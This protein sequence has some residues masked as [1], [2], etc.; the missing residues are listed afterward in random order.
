ME[1]Q[2]RVNDKA[3]EQLTMEKVKMQMREEQLQSST[4]LAHV[5][6]E[7]ERTHKEIQ[8]MRALNY[9]LQIE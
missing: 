2:L 6:D 1:Y 9:K 7:I 3:M 8:A 4:Y 5:K